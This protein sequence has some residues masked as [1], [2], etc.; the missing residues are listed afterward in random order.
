MQTYD[1]R[2]QHSAARTA[3][4]AAETASPA[5]ASAAAASHAPA[6]RVDLP[7]AMR[8]KM[9]NAFGMDLS[10]VRLYESSR[11]DD[12]GANAVA[13]GNRIAFAP[14]QADFSSRKGQA[15]LGHELSHIA[16]Q[17]RGESRGHGILN[18]PS[19]EAKADREGAMAAA[20]DTVYSAAEGASL[21]PAAS[22]GA[23]MQADWRS[24]MNYT[25]GGLGLASEIDDMIDSE[26]TAT[27]IN[28][29]S[30]THNSVTGMSKGTKDQ[31]NGYKNGALALGALAGTGVATY[32]T[33]QRYSGGDLVNGTANLLEAV[34]SGADTASY[35]AN[36]VNSFRDKGENKDINFW[37]TIG[38]IGSGA[39]RMIG[40]LVSGIGSGVTQYKL[41]NG[42]I[43]SGNLSGNITRNLDSRK[44][45]NQ[46]RRNARVDKYSGI[47]KAVSG[48]FKAGGAAW[49]G[50]DK[51]AWGLVGGKL[52]NSVGYGLDLF[53]NWNTNRMKKNARNETLDEAFGT[54]FENMLESQKNNV[55]TNGGANLS[56]DALKT[57]ALRE[58]MRQNAAQLDP[59]V[60]RELQS[61]KK[62]GRKDLY[63]ALSSHRAQTLAE[64]S[65][66]NSANYTNDAEA[67][68]KA[69]G[70]HASSVDS[71]KKG[72]LG[73]LM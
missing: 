51:S 61:K 14:G 66:A 63:R 41:E 16:S 18:D 21:T 68:V 64:D 71:K 25:L 72:I 59:I 1:T 23:P 65:D 26:F 13:Q 8:D 11:V 73:R 12:I 60:L 57:A 6:R 10:S 35:T 27:D 54:N 5:V 43:N 42:S 20:G 3:E 50:F 31:V 46:A 56:G 2:R 48:L 32:D 45:M 37:S 38:G 70:I 4:P 55:R 52:L 39:A 36:S 19:L 62:L 69:M 29:N 9:E 28:G 34:A 40:G 53:N 33:V 67:L 17:A 22:Q 15:L 58:I 24:K 47:T 49:S 30:Y 44:T 7:S